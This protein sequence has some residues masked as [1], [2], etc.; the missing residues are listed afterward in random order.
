[1]SESKANSDEGGE[2][3]STIVVKEDG[4][5]DLQNLFFDAC[6]TL[7]KFVSDGSSLPGNPNRQL[8]HKE[9]T[10][11]IVRPKTL[12]QDFY[13]VHLML[14]QS[15]EDSVK[16][17][18]DNDNELSKKL[19]EQSMLLQPFLKRNKNFRGHCCHHGPK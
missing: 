7:Q 13:D 17:I 8:T 14:A 9:F 6:S 10:S 5:V 19:S 1:M 15:L 4:G 18:G 3:R 11:C 2:V 16:F 12:V